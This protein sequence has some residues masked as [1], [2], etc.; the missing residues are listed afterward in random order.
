[1]VKAAAIVVHLAILGFIVSSL[2]SLRLCRESVR[3]QPGIMTAV[4]RDASNV[5]PL[6]VVLPCCALP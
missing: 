3:V 2:D 5:L 1:M 4:K 6:S